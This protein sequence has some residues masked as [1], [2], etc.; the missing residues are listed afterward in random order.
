[1]ILL[2][3]IAVPGFTDGQ[4]PAPARTANPFDGKETPATAAAPPATKKEAVD[5]REQRLQK[6]E[7]TLDA[8]LKEV[9]TQYHGQANRDDPAGRD[10]E[11]VQSE[12][13]ESAVSCGNQ[14]CAVSC[15]RDGRSD[16]RS[17][18]SP[19]ARYLHL[20]EGQGRGAGH[21]AQGP[22]PVLE[23]QVKADGIIVTTT[24][25]AQRVVGEFVGLLQGKVPGGPN[26]KATWGTST[27]FPPK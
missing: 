14:L 24:P 11:S 17:A 22:T 1:M 15:P 25:A 19:G 23:T 10:Q 12:L 13:S 3:L 6:L 2:A 4:P 18:D 27:Y 26:T 5:E 20:V 7:A 8:L 9:N 21:P 16:H